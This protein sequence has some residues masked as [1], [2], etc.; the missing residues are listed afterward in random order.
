MTPG[1]AAFVNVAAFFRCDVTDVAVELLPRERRSGLEGCFSVCHRGQR[2]VF[3]FDGVGGILGKGAVFCHD[4]RHR[5]AGCMHGSARQY[6]MRRYF[7][8]GDHRRR[9]NTQLLDVIARHNSDNA[10]HRLR[11]GR[12]RALSLL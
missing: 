3:H 9:R 6:G 4:S 8:P 2:F 7:L 11:R 10:R 5:N 1:A 12:C